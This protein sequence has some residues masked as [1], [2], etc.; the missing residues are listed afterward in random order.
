MEKNKPE[1]DLVVEIDADPPAEGAID[2]ATQEGEPEVHEPTPEEAVAALKARQVAEQ[3]RMAAETRAHSATVE[4][5]DSNLQLVN[6][7]IEQSKTTAAA[8]KR[9][10]ADAWQAGDMERAAEI[11][12]AIAI[13]ANQMA[14]LEDAKVQLASAPKPQMPSDPVEALV[15]QLTDPRA[16]TWIRSHPEYAA[17]AKFQELAAADQLARARGINPASD[18][19]YEFVETTLGMVA[20][21]AQIAQ[22]APRRAAA[23]PAAPVSGRGGN[24]SSPNTVHLSAAQREAAKIAGVSEKEYARNLLAA[25]QKGEILN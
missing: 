9:N 8:L 16:K 6:T 1:D 24:G 19:Y 10:L 22:P 14:R 5:Q 20:P 2:A 15:S 13:N 3:A 23:P 11:Q 25:R 7:A 18:A 4:V 12:E 21:A 17:G